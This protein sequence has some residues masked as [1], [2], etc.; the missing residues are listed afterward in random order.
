VRGASPFMPVDPICISSS[1]RQSSHSARLTCPST[2]ASWT[3]L[4][5]VSVCEKDAVNSRSMPFLLAPNAMGLA[6]VLPPALDRAARRH[7]SELSGCPGRP[8]LIAAA[9][10]PTTRW[11]PGGAAKQQEGTPCRRALGATN[12][13]QKAHAQASSRPCTRLRD[14]S[15]SCFMHK[16]LH[17]SWTTLGSPSCAALIRF[18]ADPVIKRL[19]SVHHRHRHRQRRRR[20]GRQAQLALLL[21][22]RDIRC[23]TGNWCEKRRPEVGAGAG[24]RAAQISA[25]TRSRL[26][27]SSTMREPQGCAARAADP[28]PPHLVDR[29]AVGQLLPVSG[30]RRPVSRLA[31]THCHAASRR[32]R[33]NTMTLSVHSSVRMEMNCTV[34]W[35]S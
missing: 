30:C 18:H 7:S 15:Q 1:R 4:L 33:H 34:T 6:S 25:S 8:Q 16:L 28:S 26:A 20:G 11:T 29:R 2:R 13:E 27:P 23:G 31:K 21:L 14:R 12:E 32:V 5:S 10:P 9:A 24:R 35:P 19:S 3:S 17:A 22:V